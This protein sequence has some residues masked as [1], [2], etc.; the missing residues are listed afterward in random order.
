MATLCDLTTM[1]MSTPINNSYST[2]VKQGRALIEGE[3][4]LIAN[5]ANLSALIYNSVSDLNWAGFYMVD[6][7]STLVLG[8]FQG[9]VACV[10][11]EI[12]KGVCGTAVAT[13][14]TQRVDDVHAFAGHIACDAASNSELVVPI[15]YR[16]KVIAVLDLDSPLIGRF[17]QQDQIGFEA[18]ITE[19]EAHLEKVGL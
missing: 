7:D 16:G 13:D 10:R 17:Q 6:S 11:I 19:L 3:P 5:L 14:S 18:L 15:H 4:N 12:G 2:L 8:P 1:M 9:Q